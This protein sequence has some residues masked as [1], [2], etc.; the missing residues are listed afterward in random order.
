MVKNDYF[1]HDLKISSFNDVDHGNV[2]TN[3][4][5]TVATQVLLG[6]L[7]A[8]SSEYEIFSGSEASK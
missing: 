8:L 3:T 7:Q 5:T 6:K 4:K 1:A 2:K